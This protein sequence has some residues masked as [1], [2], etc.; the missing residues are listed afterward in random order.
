[1]DQLA[2]VVTP[3]VGAENLHVEHFDAAEIDSTRDTAFIVEL[4]TGEEFEVPAG[5][6]ILSVLGDNGVEV[7][8]SCEEGVCGSCVSG[9]LEGTPDHRDSCLST[10]DRAANDQMALCVSRART[11]RLKIELS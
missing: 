8:K 1:M 6:S 4:D 7:F 9:V 3:I 5:R 10:A 11:D 2:S